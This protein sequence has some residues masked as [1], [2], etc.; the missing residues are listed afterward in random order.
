[1]LSVGAAVVAKGSE[2]AYNA[3]FGLVLQTQPPVCER[4][5]DTRQRDPNTERGNAPMNMNARC[6]EPATES[7]PRG[8]QNVPRPP[9]ASLRGAAVDLDLPEGL[10]PRIE[11]FARAHGVTVFMVLHASVAVVL[12][13]LSGTSDIAVGSPVAGRGRA[14]LDALIGMFVNT[15]VLRTEVDASATFEQLVRLVRDTDLD[16]FAAA[17]VPFEYLV[18]ALAPVDHGQGRG[19]DF[20]DPGNAAGGNQQYK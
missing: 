17:D 11:S 14:E 3:H 18:D 6:A 5:Y 19:G 20:N 15:L 9:V 7:N 2:G 16:A 4:G 8:A 1:M 13:R 12:S 10:A